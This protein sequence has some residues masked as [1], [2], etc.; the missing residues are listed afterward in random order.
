MA[1]DVLIYASPADVGHKL[2]SEVPDH[3][4]YCYWTVTGTPRQ[5]GPGA[6]VLFTDG[7]RVHA[8]GD[9]LE[10]VD[11]ELRF[12]PLERVDEPLPCEPTTRGF[13]YV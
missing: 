13:T 6:S 12:T 9:V 1:K 5:T 3:H 8:R 11:G 10:C 7:D 4:D 2:E